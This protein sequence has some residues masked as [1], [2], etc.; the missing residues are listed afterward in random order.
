MEK[1]RRI[2]LN[3]GVFM[4]AVGL[5]VFQ[6]TDGKECETAV[7]AA[8]KAGYRLIDTAAAYGNEE[9]VGAAIQASGI[10]REEIF[11]TTKLWVQD[12][13]YETARQAFSRSLERLGL[14]WIDLYMLHQP[15]GDYYGAWRAMEDLCREGRIRALGVCNFEADRLADLALCSSIP[16]AVDQIELHPYFQEREVTAAARE[17]GVAVQAWSPLGKG[18][19]GILEDEVISRIAKIHVKTAAQVILRWHLQQG[20]AVIPK[21]IHEER[22][23]ENF[24]LWDFSLTD[25][26]MEEIRA[27]ERGENGRLGIDRRT[28]EA[29]A[30]MHRAKIHP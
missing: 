28:A 26:E 20:V 30:M 3:N 8:L 1:N 17:Y 29:A 6:I 15:F 12:A 22:I 4:P 13:G 7:L 11:V 21:S 14:T 16:P 19:Q 10:P 23:R 27:L 25:G 2:R 24:D 9:A 18:Q 5:G